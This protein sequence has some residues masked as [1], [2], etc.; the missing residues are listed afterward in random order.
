MLMR[1]SWLVAG[2]LALTGCEAQ[3]GAASSPDENSAGVAIEQSAIDRGLVPGPD[4]ILFEGR[5]ERRSDL[6]TD[7]FCALGDGGDGF[8]IGALAVYGPNSFCEGQ[9]EAE[10]DGEKVSIRF[11]EAGACRFEATFDG[12]ELRF[13]GE[14]PR[15]CAKLCTARASF[16]GTSYF[17]VEDGADRAKAALGREIES[18]CG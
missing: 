7:T 6:G 5:Y 3:D 10:R 14:I 15:D 1:I 11:D 18:L 17:L 4:T 12:V 9:G 2:A 16:A 13:P 8:V